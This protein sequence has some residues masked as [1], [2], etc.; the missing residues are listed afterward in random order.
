MSSDP[1]AEFFS[2]VPIVPGWYG[3]IPAMGDFVSRRLPEAFVTRWDRWLAEGIAESKA[4][5]GDQW[6]DAFLHAPIWNFGLKPGHID[7]RAWFGVMMPSVDRVG[8]YFPL[9]IAAPVR[10]P[11]SANQARLVQAWL[12]GLASAALA[13]LAEGHTVDGLEAALAAL[14]VPELVSPA[15]VPSDGPWP[16]VG[17]DFT[18]AVSAAALD[19]LWQ[20]TADLSLWWCAGGDSIRLHAGL[21][22]SHA[23]KF[24]LAAPSP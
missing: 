8:R 2:P 19:C 10:L 22:E 17:D 4:T 14:P 18:E 7:A 6:L 15:T 1:L 24:L 16:L 3:K 23:F 5:L 20:R 21:P 9:T 12:G 11:A 13:S